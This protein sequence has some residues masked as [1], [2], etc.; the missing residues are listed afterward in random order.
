MGCLITNYLTLQRHIHIGV[1][2]IQIKQESVS[3]PNTQY[4]F[5]AVTHTPQA[6]KIIQYWKICKLLQNKKNLLSK[7]IYLFTP[8]VTN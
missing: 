5:T 4:S 7:R 8:D 6:R 1:I 2:S 3:T